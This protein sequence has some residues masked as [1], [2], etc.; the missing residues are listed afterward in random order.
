[1]Q[2]TEVRMHLSGDSS[3]GAQQNQKILNRPIPAEKNQLQS[4]LKTSLGEGREM[5]R[6]RFHLIPGLLV[7]VLNP[8]SSV[9][10]DG[11][12]WRVPLLCDRTVIN[13]CFTSVLLKGDLK[14]GQVLTALITVQTIRR[15]EG[16]ITDG[17]S[18]G[19]FIKMLF[20]PSGSTFIAT[21]EINVSGREHRSAR[22]AVWSTAACRWELAA[23][24]M[25]WE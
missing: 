20:V 15:P 9:C 12:G 14:T 18:K 8:W 2:T 22:L 25:C 3:F 23:W 19:V 6:R 13:C 5:S 11:V 17:R 1:M 24:R 21:M 16:P 7:V 10:V 4:F